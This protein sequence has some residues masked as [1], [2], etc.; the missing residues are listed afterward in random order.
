MSP[1]YKQDSVAVHFTWKPNWEAVRQLLPTIEQA[2]EPFNARPHWG[3][4]FT[5]SPARV[6]S[7][8]GKLPQFQQLLLQYDPEGK[9]RNDYLNTYI[10]GVEG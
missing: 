4:L 8:Y 3:K 9:F 1:C 2:L 5:M 6:Q 7:L 10:W